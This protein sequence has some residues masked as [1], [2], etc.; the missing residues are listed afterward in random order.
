[1]AM[2]YEFRTADDGDLDAINAVIEAAISGWSVTDRVKRLAL[3]IYRYD[4]HDLAHLQIDQLFHGGALAGVV[5]WEAAGPE[6]TT[7]R[8]REALL[9]G[10]YVRP[11]YQGSG[12]GR[13]LLQHASLAAAAAGFA[14]FIVKA[15]R[16]AT[17]FFERMGLQPV[18]SEAQ[19]Y[20]YLFWLDF[21]AADRAEQSRIIEMAWEDRTPF[22]AIEQQFGLSQSDVIRLMRRE[23][24][25]G[26]FRLWRRRGNG[27]RTKHRALR[28]PK[29][30]RSHAPGQYKR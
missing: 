20:P 10:I 12:T 23:L 19:D 5:A 9:H 1:M 3:P 17:G 14:G 22:E 15:S 24:R 28:D 4:R 27:R 16:D 25:P 21:A 7:G 18:R 6:D 2:Q 13:L 11:E 26:S 29:V 8:N 30:L